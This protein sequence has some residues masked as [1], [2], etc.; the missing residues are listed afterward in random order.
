MRDF[1]TLPGTS[2]SAA[3]G[4]ND[5]GQVVGVAGSI[6]GF[7]NHAFFW[8][9]GV[10]T[11]LGNI[12]GGS[13][14]YAGGINNRGQVVGGSNGRAVLWE[15]VAGPSTETIPKFKLVDLGALPGGSSSGAAAINDRG[16][17]AGSS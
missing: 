10:V 11:D 8:E 15:P 17:V 14:S 4:V 3:Y 1:G 9:N 5:R 16:Q 7:S 12:P 6:G 2:F 13:S